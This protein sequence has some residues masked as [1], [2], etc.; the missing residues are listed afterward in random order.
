MDDSFIFPILENLALLYETLAIL[1]TIKYTEKEKY[2]LISECYEQSC[3]YYAK[4]KK[5][6]EYCTNGLENSRILAEN[7]HHKESLIAADKALS[8]SLYLTFDTTSKK[9]L[10]IKILNNLGVIYSKDEQTK[11]S[12]IIGVN[13]FKRIIELSIK[14]DDLNLVIYTNSNALRNKLGVAKNTKFNFKCDKPTEINVYY[15][16]NMAYSNFLLGMYLA[17]IDNFEKAF[18]LSNNV[19]LRD[20]EVKSEIK[21]SL[22]TCYCKILDYDNAKFNFIDAL[23]LTNNKKS[24]ERIQAKIE[25]CDIQ[26]EVSESSQSDVAEEEEKLGTEVVELTKILQKAES[27]QELKDNKDELVNTKTSFSIKDMSDFMK[28]LDQDTSN[29]TAVDL[30]KSIKTQEIEK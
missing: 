14:D 7:G 29:I 4:C 16:F 26:N 17:A 21:E 10:N 25:M 30:K 8:A 24:K 27:D 11:N 12:T 15:K 5:W 19:I 9:L 6:V 13:L 28:S 18:E 1:F 20:K 23:K 2:R 3:I 22:A